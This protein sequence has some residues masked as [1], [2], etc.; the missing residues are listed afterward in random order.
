MMLLSL[1][2]RLAKENLLE[3]EKEILREEIRQ[4]ESAMNME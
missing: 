2:L 3:A 1:K 4:L